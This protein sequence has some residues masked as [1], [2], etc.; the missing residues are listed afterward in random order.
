MFRNQQDIPLVSKP[1]G[2]VDDCNPV[3]WLH[4]RYPGVLSSPSRVSGV[5]VSLEKENGNYLITTYRLLKTRE[6]FLKVRIH[7]MM[8]VDEEP[9]ELWS[10]LY[11]DVE[12]PADPENLKT[13]ARAKSR[14]LMLAQTYCESIAAVL[15]CRHE[16]HI[17]TAPMRDK[18][19]IMTHFYI[20]VTPTGRI[21]NYTIT[22]KEKD[23]GNS[24][25]KYVL[26]RFLSPYFSVA[27]IN[28]FESRAFI[29]DEGI[30]NVFLALSDE[31]KG[32]ISRFLIDYY[33]IC[34]QRYS[35]T[36]EEAYTQFINVM[37]E[38]Q[39]Q[40]YIQELK[41]MEAGV[42]RRSY[43]VDEIRDK[44]EYVMHFIKM[45]H[46]DSRQEYKIMKEAFFNLESLLDK[47][48]SWL[49]HPDLSL[50]QTSLL[51]VKIEE[52]SRTVGDKRLLLSELWRR[53]EK[54]EYWAEWFKKQ[55]PTLFSMLDQ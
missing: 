54:I 36:F 55:F 45:H 26:Q 23:S 27:K 28:D 30:D 43:T 6:K 37:A 18:F 15:D 51:E 2:N 44:F 34:T 33:T 8:K 35:Q 3:Q 4:R 32:E 24:Q 1:V 41:D 53:F 39:V 21:K 16:R 11:T 12:C 19:R 50:A 46:E 10:T 7:W 20:D 9:V 29:R 42:Q 49:E 38:E 48:H 25:G 5:C 31:K 47:F 40:V 14:V 13:V 22:T 52:L 17:L